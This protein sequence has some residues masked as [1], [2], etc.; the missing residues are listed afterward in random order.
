MFAKMNL[1]VSPPLQILP[2]H[3]AHFRA[4]GYAVI[5][6]VFR[7][8]EVSE[9]K[10]AFNRVYAEGLTHPRSFRHGNVFYRI[11]EDPRCG[12]IV[13]YVQW[14]SYNDP[15]LNRFRQDPRLFR[16]IAP[17]LGDDIKQIINQLHWK[18]P[19]A[20]AEF[21]Y[22]QDIRFRRPRSAYRDPANSYVQTG[23]AVDP[24]RPEN[25][26]MR[27]FPGSHFLPELDFGDGRV[28]DTPPDDRCLAQAGLAPQSGIDLVLDAGDVALWHLHLVHGSG[29]NISSG[30]RRFYINGYVRAAMCDR[31]EWTFRG[32]V[33]VALGSPVLVH[34]EDL[35]LRPEPHYVDG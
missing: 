1:P 15:V 3:V 9:L 26:A 34:Y 32:G 20:A 5:K 4:Q 23:I 10:S 12:R 16:L 11:A 22:H 27:I 25:G 31:G 33:P 30:D 14:P 35:Y 17:F 24:H 6:G 19:G 7:P 8:Q 18:P 28:M 21:G 29:A 2:A 13:R